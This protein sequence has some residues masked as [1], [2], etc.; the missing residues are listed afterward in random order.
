MKLV[1]ISVEVNIKTY[2]PKR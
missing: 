1:L 2:W